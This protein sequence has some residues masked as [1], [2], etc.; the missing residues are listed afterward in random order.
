M[1]ETIS[2]AILGK[3]G[4]LVLEYQG[5]GYFVVI[6]SPPPWIVGFAGIVKRT[7]VHVL[8]LIDV[9][10]FFET[11]LM[12]LERLWV[13][14]NDRVKDIGE[15]VEVDADGKESHLRA[16]LLSV[17]NRRL[18]LLSTIDEK[19]VELIRKAREIRSLARGSADERRDGTRG[20]PGQ[21][22]E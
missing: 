14:T 15:W 10:T 12:N 3:L 22:T 8:E 4:Y 2:D 18:M 13:D 16:I 17:Q 20:H 21:V 6:G 5:R 9:F 7:E 1:I 19:T 11:A